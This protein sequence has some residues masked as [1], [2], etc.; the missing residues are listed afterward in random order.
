M[1]GNMFLISVR[2]LAPFMLFIG[3]I[4]LLCYGIRIILWAIG[5]VRLC[6]A[7]RTPDVIPSSLAPLGQL[8]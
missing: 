1:F 6:P 7:P 3:T 4:V 2:I 8:I 5:L